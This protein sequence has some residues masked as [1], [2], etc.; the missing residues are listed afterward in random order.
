[1]KQKNSRA[2]AA[3]VSNDYFHQA[4]V[5][6]QSIKCFE[7]KSDFV[8]FVIGYDK[9]DPDYQN[10]GFTI[11]DAK[12]LNPKEW[13]QFLFQYRAK[14]AAC[15]LKPLAILHLLERYE[16]VICLDT[17]MK[18]F[19]SLENGWEGLER[20]DLALTPQYYQ[21]IPTSFHNENFRLLV[22][23]SGIFNAGYV[24]ATRSSSDFL[25]WW[26]EQTKHNCIESIFRGIFVDQKWLDSA[27]GLVQRLHVVRDRSYNVAYW[28]LHERL[29]HKKKGH[30][31]VDKEPLTFFHFSGLSAESDFSPYKKE[32]LFCELFRDYYQELARERKKLFPKEYPFCHFKDGESI[33]DSWR[34]WMRRGISELEKIKNPFLLNRSARE[35]MEEVMVKRSH[36]FR[37]KLE[38][39]V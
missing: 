25:K 27:V 3:I 12:V 2:I 14:Q 15:A 22:R 36:Q 31:F 13:H 34:E 39:E 23:M 10:A 21:P 29:L 8:L 16:K 17:D 5:L 30:Y 26:W 24:G 6:W 35:Q 37:P 7:K 33:D 28:N 38:R 9:K 4:V 1:M 11:V 32:P 18:L 19:Q 20:A